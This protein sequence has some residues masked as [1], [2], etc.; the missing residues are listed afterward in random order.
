MRE[1]AENMALGGIQQLIAWIGVLV[2]IGAAA[3]ATSY[4]RRTRWAA[5]V[6]G[7]FAL[8]ALNGIA[9]QILLPMIIKENPSNVATQVSRASFG[10]S[11]VGLMGFAILVLG[12]MGTFSEL[13]R[14]KRIREP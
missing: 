5:A 4:L 6:A 2:T 1:L 10:L 8:L 7:G 13:S 11:L 9:G 14:A 3:M 12:V